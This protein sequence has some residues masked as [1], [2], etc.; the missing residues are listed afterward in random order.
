MRDK[1][2]DV[3]DSRSASSAAQ[4]GSAR[5]STCSCGSALRSLPQTGQRP[6]Q[7]SRQRILSGQ[8]ERD[9]VVRPGREVEP[10]VLEVLRPL[11]VALGLRRLVLAQAELERQLG[12]LQAAE[13]RAV[14]RDVERELEDGAARRARDRE[15][16]GRGIRP[17]LVGL[18]AEDERLELDL[19]ALARLVAGAE[20]ERAEVERGHAAT[21]AR[22]AEASQGAMRRR[23]ASRGTARQRLLLRLLAAEVRLD[24]LRQSASASSC[25]ACA[26]EDEH[27]DRGDDDGAGGELAPADR[28]S[29][30]RPAEQDGDRRVDVGVRRDE[31]A[32]RAAPQQPAV[33]GEGDDRAEDDEEGE[34][35]DR[36]RRDRRRMHVADLS[37]RRARDA[38]AARRRRASASRRR[39]TAPAAAARRGRRPS[40]PPRRSAAARI[41]AAPTGSTCA[42][43]PTSSATPSSPVAIPAS[44]PSESRTPKN[45]RSRS[46]EKSGTAATRSAVSPEATRCSAQATPPVSTNR[47][48]PPTTAA[49]VHSRRPGRAAATS[50]RHSGPAVEK[51]AGEP[52]ADREHEQR[53]Q[54]PVGDGDREIRRSPDDVDDPE[55][56]D[57]LRPHGS[58]VP[59][60]IDQ[61]KWSYYS[62]RS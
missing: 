44:A 61:H 42:L 16:G 3:T 22:P 1:D 24:R 54:R 49:A 19:D 57:D 12:V 26:G 8:R 52:E 13:A 55:R 28:L 62:Y 31:D 23:S 45:V 21:V 15:L 9:R 33:G 5:S 39:G 34:R 25:G 47:S 2:A 53:R 59:S 48:S 46:A 56:D 40:R 29:G 14:E 7:S 11:V 18:A 58:M 36:A 10:I 43:G 50:P 4:R 51:P 37:H 27:P 30:E 41:T 32:R 35:R 38:R 6:A 20:A 60:A 17:R